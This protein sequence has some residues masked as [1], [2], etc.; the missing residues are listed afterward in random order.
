MAPAGAS[1]GQ[2][3]VP[4]GGGVCRD[5][6]GGNGSVGCPDKSSPVS[7][8]FLRTV[9][10][11]VWPEATLEIRRLAVMAPAGYWQLS[12]STR[13]APVH[14]RPTPTPCHA[15]ACRACCQ[16]PLAAC[17][18]DRKKGSC[19]MGGV[20]GLHAC[21]AHSA[22]ELSLRTISPCCWT[23]RCRTEAIAIHTM[24]HMGT[25]AVQNALDM[26]QGRLS[27]AMAMIQDSMDRVRRLQTET[28]DSVDWSDAHNIA[29]IAQ[30]TLFLILAIWLIFANNAKVAVGQKAPLEQRH[31]VCA[32][33]ST[34]VAL[35]SGFFNIM[36]LTGID[37][38]DIPGYSG[39]FVLQLARPVEWVLTCPILQLK[40]VVLAG[41]RVPSYRRFMMP[42]LSAAV[43]LCG[44]AATFTEGAL[45]YVWFTFGSIFCFIMF[46]HNAL[47]IGEN[48]EGEESLLRGDSD[49]RRLT[50]L[51]IITWFPFPIWFILSPEGFNLVDSELVIEMGWVAL[52]LLAKFSM[53]ILGQRMKMSHQKKMEAAREL[54]GMA[55]GDAVSGEALD[56][57]AL[58]E[59]STKGGRRMMDPA[60]YGLGVG[61]DAESEEK[62]I[63]LVAD[64]MV[65]LQLA[66]HTERLIKLLV[67]S[68][69]TNT[70][71]LERL[72]QDRCM[73][74]CL[75][76]AL[77]DAIQRRW[78]SEK[79]NMGQDVGI[80]T[81][82]DLL[83]CAQ[84]YR[85][86]Q[87]GVVEK[88]DPFMKVLEAN[89]ERLS[90]TKT[91]Y[92]NGVATPPIG[93]VADLSGLNEQIASAVQ[94]AVMPLHE[95][96]LAK[97]QT[98]QDN[99]SQSLDST[100]ESVAQRMD[101]GQV[102]LM[103]TVNAC[104]V[105]LHKLDSSQEV[106]LQKLDAQ[107]RGLDQIS[108]SCTTLHAKLGEVQTTMNATVAEAV[109][110]SSKALLENLEGTQ[111]DLLRQTTEANSILQN[112]VSTQKTMV[113]KLESG[114]DSMVRNL[115]EME[116]SLDKKLADF[117]E[118][119]VSS[120]T[121]SSES[122]LASLKEQMDALNDQ[123]N[124]AVVA[125]E[126]SAAVLDERMTDVR[127]QNLM[128]LD[129]LTSSNDRVQ[130]FADN[131]DTLRNLDNVTASEVRNILTEHLGKGQTAVSS[132][133]GNE[134]EGNGTME[135]M[136]SRLEDSA[137]RLE[138][139]GMGA[140]KSE[141]A[142]IEE[143]LA[144]QQAQIVGDAMQEVKDLQMGL[145]AQINDF[146]ARLGSLSEPGSQADAPKERADRAERPTGSPSSRRGSKRNEVRG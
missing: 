80:R 93:S 92:P 111:Q 119:A 108:T 49:Y 130:N 66:N 62:M 22:T 64:T 29:Q 42:L 30:G 135:S 55:P 127:R 68:G 59:S 71:V 13:S 53:I 110:S 33:L 19:S 50:L 26:E 73:E 96:V 128:M 82:S 37:D 76:W 5:Y 120:Y 63:E 77:V 3:G 98:L 74:L 54:Y 106:V 89:K 16:Y 138:A 8:M 122:V 116:K 10:L 18:P 81:M 2:L 114:N 65:T 107:Q 85:E 125:A 87:G 60:D 31:A 41:A 118:S 99:M 14:H 146:S 7:V 45:R 91:G 90:G 143:R 112:V 84:E 39:G 4:V 103:Q 115:V 140:V 58:A 134:T 23:V 124:T 46:Y 52:N 12:H 132:E 79:M 48:S 70:A 1:E 32:T 133:G 17:D 86:D 15:A 25:R 34:A 69:V 28:C 136:V 139:N 78:S 109:G 51:L 104:Q 137:A 61:E 141:L 102:T 57:K 20:V 95:T 145:V 47:Q 142:D 36:Q 126:R 88:A 129:L 9:E 21:R 131:L 6:S 24:E 121:V 27:E 72:N 67:E 35:F 100:Q 44:V 97:L 105:L 38:F 40:L 123:S 56:Q 144:K 83:R 113:T 94:R 43:L 75:P 11:V 117:G 101:F